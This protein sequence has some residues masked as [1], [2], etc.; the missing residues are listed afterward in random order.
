MKGEARIGGLNENVA[1]MAELK[2]E[3]ERDN[4]C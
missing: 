3:S 4:L 2:R 1:R